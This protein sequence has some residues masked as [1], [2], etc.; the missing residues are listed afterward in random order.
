MGTPCTGPPG[1]P[2]YTPPLPQR[3]G[4]DPQGGCCRLHVCG[5]TPCPLPRCPTA[6]NSYVDI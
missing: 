4:R 3:V 6:L 1:T 2:T 5:P